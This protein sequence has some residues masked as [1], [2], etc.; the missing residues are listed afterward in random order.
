MLN[1]SMEKTLLLEK[2]EQALE[3]GVDVLQIWN[4]WPDKMRMAEKKTLINS[5]VNIVAPYRVPVLIN[6][7]W[8]LLKD[9]PIDG[10][11]FDRKPEQYEKIKQEVGRIFM[12]GITCSNDLT[13][14]DWA[15]ENQ[16]DYVSFCSVF[17]SPSVDSCEIVRPETI[18]KAR[19]RTQ[20]PLFLSGGI[21][22]ENLSAL[23]NLD[24]NGVAVVSG[25]LNAASPKKSAVSY[26]NALKNL[27]K[28]KT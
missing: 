26:K 15:E 1:P 19:E 14:I 6:E 27:N 17:P 20:L 2:L 16:V 7:E 21:S 5:I 23:Q 28:E 9:T 8:R 4:N 13:I 18:R 25:I 12:A 22:V 24:F 11:H 10:V 3:G